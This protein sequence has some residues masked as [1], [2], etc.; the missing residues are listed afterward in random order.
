M[1]APHRGRNGSRHCGRLRVA[2]AKILTDNLGFDVNPEDIQPATGRYRTDWRQDV[3]RWE[4]FANNGR[5]PVVAGC[6]DT[7]TRFVR[8]AKRRGC[9]IEDYEI[10]VNR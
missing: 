1:R 5:L 3:Y 2:A 10:V 8:E 7:L 6:W 4:L 9:R